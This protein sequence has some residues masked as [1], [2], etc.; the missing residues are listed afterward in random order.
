LALQWFGLTM[1][2]G[3]KARSKGDPKEMHDAVPARGLMTI[4]QAQEFLQMG[5]E[6]IDWL[7]RTGQ[8]IKLRIHGK[9]FFSFRDVEQLILTYRNVAIRKD[10]PNVQVS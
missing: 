1:G 6:D 5:P 8:L 4:S 10:H 3:A 2:S 9:E 7:C